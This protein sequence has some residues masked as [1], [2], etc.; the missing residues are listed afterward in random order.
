MCRRD[1]FFPNW[2]DVRPSGS[3]PI[4]AICPHERCG[5]TTCHFYN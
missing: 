4:P 2:L 5:S 1:G 3:M